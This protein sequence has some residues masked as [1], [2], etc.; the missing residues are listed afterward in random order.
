MK[1]IFFLV[2]LNI[3][4]FKVTNAQLLF[5]N[6][7][8]I[9]SEKNAIIKVEGGT[10]NVGYIYHEGFVQIDDFY[11]NGNIGTSQGSGVYEVAGDWIN[12]GVFI[13]DTS[14]VYLNGGT[15]LITGDTMTN[16]YNLTL[17]GSGIKRQTINSSVYSILNLNA[18]EL[19]T[20]QDTM[21]IVNTSPSA[22]T[23]SSTFGSEG[24]VSSLDTGT[25]V[26]YTNSTSAYLFPL[27]S[28]I[29]TARY[30]QLLLSPNTS[31][32]NIYSGSFVND[33]ASLKGYN[34]SLFDTSL[35]QVLP[36]Y[37][38]KVNRLL[39]VSSADMDLF[40]LQSA[41]GYWDAI[42][43]WKN[44]STQWKNIYLNTPTIGAY[45]SVKRLNWSDFS[46]IP[47]ALISAKPFL[48]ITG[49][50]LVCNGSIGVFNGG[51]AG[52]GYIYDWSLSGGNFVG[53]STSSTANVLFPSSGIYNIT[54][55]ATNPLSGCSSNLSSY[56]VVVGGGTVADF[57]ISSS[58]TLPAS[59]INL[60]DISTNAS[61][62]IWDFGN[63]YTSTDQNPQTSY[64]TTGIYTITLITTDSLGCT[65]T[66]T[67]VLEINPSILIPNIF[68]PNGDG[69]NDVFLI[70]QIGLEDFKIDLFNRWGELLYTGVEGTA[71]WDG[72][73]PTGEKCPEGTYFF[74]ITGQQGTKPFEYKGYVQLTR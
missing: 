12:S 23:H 18:L 41:D 51:I 66:T 70:P 67:H 54:M 5:N 74:I 32:A 45:N 17:Q 2:V 11:W 26:R 15:Q 59:I 20:D 62:W 31:S 34:T 63:G 30:R 8:V 28:S 25:L 57:S 46:N 60:T 43:N 65:D 7:A 1:K 71:A 22:I 37:F 61:S 19:A 72:T 21:F 36:F 9:S 48:N 73:T 68:T 39:G 47:Y 42:G 24:F 10:L 13:R 44:G 14:H 35:C 4:I 27:G 64:S 3:I 29:G 16:Y 38:H 58:T 6:G 69:A 52:S 40:Y 56:S 49:D 55:V 53:D 50:T 33:S